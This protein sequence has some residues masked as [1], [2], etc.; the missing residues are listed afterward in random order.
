MNESLR[1]ILIR[2][3]GLRVHPYDDATGK[4]LKLGDTLKGKLTIGVGRNL[5][6]RPLS[7]DEVLYL[8][9]ND[10]KMVISELDEAL[11]WWKLLDPARKDVLIS[12]GFN[13]G[14][15]TP[16]EKAKLLSFKRTLE[17]IRTGRYQEAADAMLESKW[18]KQVGGRAEELATIMRTAP[19]KV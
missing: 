9:D 16:P 5:T 14:V 3:E 11:P 10:I 17:L 15:L 19:I 18:A 7:Q 13:L 4:P 2:H 8:L 12:M 1:D 6:D